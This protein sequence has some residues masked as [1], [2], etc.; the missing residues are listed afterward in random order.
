[1]TD[2]TSSQ[3]TSDEEVQDAEVV[4]TPTHSTSSNLEER[5]SIEQMIKTTCPTFLEFVRN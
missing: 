1:M 3:T 2:Q 4:E 5:L